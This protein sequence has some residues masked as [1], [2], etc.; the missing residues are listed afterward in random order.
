MSFKSNDEVS[1]TSGIGLDAVKRHVSPQKQKEV[2][3]KLNQDKPVEPAV[4]PENRKEIEEQGKKMDQ[5]VPEAAS[6]SSSA[7][8]D[9]EETRTSRESA[10]MEVEQE[11]T[12]R[13]AAPANSE[14]QN[15]MDRIADWDKKLNAKAAKHG[16][17]WVNK[18]NLQRTLNS[19]WQSL[20]QDKREQFQT[21][22]AHWKFRVNGNKVVR[23]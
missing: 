8:K 19:I 6:S 20:P 9:I 23:G 18:G 3:D 16:I 14:K 21:D 22:I 15:A 7:S 4:L 1:S 10:S 13:E 2:L 5:E 12:S 17:D 11:T